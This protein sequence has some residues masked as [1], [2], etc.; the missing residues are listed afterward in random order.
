MTPTH[1]TPTELVARWKGVVKA[2]TL[3]HWRNKRQGPPYEKFGKA[4]LYPIAELEAWE[5]K[6]RVETA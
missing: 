4:V 2:Q 1:L 5:A 3:A 6:Q